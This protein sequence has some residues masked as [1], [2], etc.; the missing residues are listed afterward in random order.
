MRRAVIAAVA[1][2]LV[3]CARTHTS[4]DAG[5]PDD[6]PRIDAPV[7]RDAD[8]D[9]F[10]SAL[11]G[12]DDCDDTDA[13]LFPRATVCAGPTTTARCEAGRVVTTACDGSAP[14]CDAR[15]GECAAT[16]CGDGVEQ[17]GEECDDGNTRARDGCAACVLEPCTASSQCAADRPFCSRLLPDGTFRCQGGAGV[18][19]AGENCM[20]DSECS[21]GWCDELQGKCGLA[22]TSETDCMGADAI[23]ALSGPPMRCL[24]QCFAAADCRPDRVCYHARA[25]L[26]G[27]A[28]VA[29]THCSTGEVSPTPYRDGDCLCIDGY[30]CATGACAFSAGGCSVVCRNDADC[31]DPSRPYCVDATPPGDF[32]RPE[33]FWSEHGMRVLLCGDGAPRIDRIC[34]D[35]NGDREAG[36]SCGGTDCADLPSDSDVVIGCLSGTQVDTCAA[37]VRTTVECPS[38][39]PF[40]RYPEGVCV[41]A[42]GA[43]GDR[44]VHPGEECD[45]GNHVPGDGCNDCIIE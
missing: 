15:V 18:R 30:D 39:T 31:R 23:C 25:L 11:C 27:G 4:G 14:V 1:F 6:V 32:V 20:L 34:D 16:A 24:F 8:G 38:E 22:C 9:G 41:P 44:F 7:C 3:G 2:A 45:D 42:A 5:V 19:R 17:P 35:H 21:T 10:A 37:A 12:G 26:A 28:T 13:A 40:C 29:D 33:Q 43:C 36:A